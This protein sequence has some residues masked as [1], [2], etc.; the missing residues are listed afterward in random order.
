VVS[1]LETSP[2][3]KPTISRTLEQHELLQSITAAYLT[4][5]VLGAGWIIYEET[6]DVKSRLSHL[7]QELEI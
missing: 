5:Q 3:C 6:T 1:I 7:P 2:A 4:T